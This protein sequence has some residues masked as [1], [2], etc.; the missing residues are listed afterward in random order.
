MK[1]NIIV[2]TGVTGQDGSNMVDFL[3]KETS[4]HIVGCVRRLSV[5]N[6]ENIEQ[7]FTNPRFEK[8]YFD[9]T[10]PTSVN[11]IIKKY[12]PEYFQ[13]YAQASEHF[14][15]VRFSNGAL[16]QDARLGIQ[17]II[18][19]PGYDPDSVREAQRQLLRMEQGLSPFSGV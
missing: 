4:Y 19:T 8:V 13:A 14:Q 3:L 2:L 7:H 17:E 1:N 10:D 16:D 9:L 5:P 18:N 15:N 6:D 11:S 12:K